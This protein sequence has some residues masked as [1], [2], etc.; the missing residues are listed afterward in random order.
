[1][2][3][4]TLFL[5][6][7]FLAM[8]LHAQAPAPGAAIPGAEC[9][10]RTSAT[11]ASWLIQG[12]DPF[13]G[14]IPEGTFGVTFVNEGTA[15]CRFTPTFE[16]VQPPFGLSKGT[17]KP[18]G[19]ALLNLTDTQDVTPRAG[20][21]QRNPSQR[22]LAL[23]PNASRTLLYKL[24]ADPDDVRN[25]G[26]FT[27]DVTLEAQDSSF[28]SLGGTRIVLGIDVLPSAR[29]GLAGAYTMSD[30]QAVVDLGDLRPGVAPVPLQLRVASTGSYDLN[31]TSANSG[32]L[33]LGA[34]D[35]YVPYSL[36]IG[37][38]SIN[39]TGA[40]TISGKSNDGLRREALPIQFLI[41]D[42]SD[43]RAGVY[44]DV[45]SISVTAR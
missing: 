16:L 23:S 21:T 1:M 10:I 13:D 9:L 44:S 22:M 4:P 45:V 12:Y 36:A 18:I 37:G 33:R 31:V 28:R 8:P 43:R 3:R 19:Y 5:A 29:I 42:T 24:V 39:L 7:A 30:G 2:L 14:S 40:R 27:Q 38:N 6:A 15:E 25:S 32:R 17:G 26:T 34:S 20:R 41:G 35:W 11:P